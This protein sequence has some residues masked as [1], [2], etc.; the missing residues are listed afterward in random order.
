MAMGIYSR[1]N[2]RRI[3]QTTLRMER[4]PRNAPHL[5]NEHNPNLRPS[6]YGYCAS[7][8]TAAV[9]AT[10]GGGSA[11]IQVKTGSALTTGPLTVPFDNAGGAITGP[12]YLLL[13][14]AEGAWSACVSPC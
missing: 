5:A 3:K 6:C 13:L 4:Q 10:L 9:G 12:K 11:V 8:A 1:R 2:M 7:G 14:W